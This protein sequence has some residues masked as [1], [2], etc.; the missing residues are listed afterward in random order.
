M[1]DT[2]AAEN[3]SLN[4]GLCPVC[5]GS[6]REGPSGG[7]TLTYYCPTGGHYGYA[8]EWYE[9]KACL[10]ASDEEQAHGL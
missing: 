10:R 9:A 6:L 3:E 7:L 2:T 5:H 1:R 8:F 4:Q